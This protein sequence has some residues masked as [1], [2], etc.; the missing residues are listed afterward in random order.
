MPTSAS[1]TRAHS[2][3]SLARPKR[4]CGRRERPAPAF[5][6]ALSSVR[7]QLQMRTWKVV[8]PLVL[9]SGACALVYE[10]TWLREFRLLFGASTLASATVLALFIAGVG[11]G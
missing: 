6:W 8:T 2:R 11:L 7:S 10:V 5:L 9:A 4:P 1:S 3:R